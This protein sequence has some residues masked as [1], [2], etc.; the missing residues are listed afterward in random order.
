MPLKW[1]GLGAFRVTTIQ[2]EKDLRKGIQN[3]VDD[4]AKFLKFQAEKLSP[5]DTGKLRASWAMSTQRRGASRT[6]YVFN[7]AKTPKGLFYGWFVEHGTIKM[8]PRKFLARAIIRSKAQQK[9]WLKRLEK[10]LARRYNNGT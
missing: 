9:K 6:V 5:V 7:T 3:V 8:A 4:T 2:S 1:F 10:D